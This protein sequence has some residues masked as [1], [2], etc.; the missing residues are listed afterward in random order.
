MIVL[1]AITHNSFL[2]T[3][4]GSSHA[5]RLSTTNAKHRS[6]GLC[7]CKSNDSD[8]DPS[9]PEGD[10]RKQEFLAKIA[11]LQA[12]KLRLSEFLDERSEYLTQFAE[13]AGAEFDKIGDDAFK[14]LDEASDRV[15]RKNNY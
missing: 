7:L 5:P 8:S 12:Q 2:A 1:K 6:S 11:Q 15:C 14:G 10:T 9:P 13:E 3:N 4:H